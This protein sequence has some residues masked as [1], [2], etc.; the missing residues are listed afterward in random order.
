MSWSWTKK[1]IANDGI[2][3]RASLNLATNLYLNYRFTSE[4]SSTSLTLKNKVRKKRVYSLTSR[5]ICQTI[6]SDCRCTSRNAVLSFRQNDDDIHSNDCCF[7]TFSQRHS[8]WTE[9]LSKPHRKMTM[10]KQLILSPAKSHF[11]P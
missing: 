5:A 11:F 3:A 8:A 4:N 9:S 2:A 7:E 6:S 10:G 1:R